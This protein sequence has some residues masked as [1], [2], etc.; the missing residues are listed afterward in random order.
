MGIFFKD[1]LDRFTLQQ[2]LVFKSTTNKKSIFCAGLVLIGIIFS[3]SEKKE[4][5]LL[6][7]K[8]QVHKMRGWHCRIACM[9]LW[10]KSIQS[11]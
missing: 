1:I 9:G 7:K 4:V 10:S 11:W 8:N 3:F 2:L 5:V 6:N